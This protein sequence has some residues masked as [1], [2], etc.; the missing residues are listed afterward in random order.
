[1]DSPQRRRQSVATALKP[2]L[3]RRGAPPRHHGGRGSRVCFAEDIEQRRAPRKGA[4][5]LARALLARHLGPGSR[6]DSLWSSVRLALVTFTAARGPASAWCHA[7]PPASAARQPEAPPTLLPPQWSI[8]YRMA[9]PTS[10]LQVELVVDA[11]FAADMAATAL[12]ALQA[13]RPRPGQTY[14]ACCGQSL[15]P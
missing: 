2:A 14:E 8:P 1:M 15:K 11:V 10:L 4:A 3:R 13:R 9:L 7:A 5:S 6:A 12:F